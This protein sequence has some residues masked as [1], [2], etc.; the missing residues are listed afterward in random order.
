MSRKHPHTALPSRTAACSQ[1][2]FQ[3][4]VLKAG[5]ILS[6]AHVSASHSA[7]WRSRSSPSDDQTFFL[8]LQRGQTPGHV[9]DN[10]SVRQ[11]RSRLFFLFRA[12]ARDFR[13]A[14]PWHYDCVRD[15][16]ACLDIRFP[17]F[18]LRDP[19]T[20]VHQRLHGFIVGLGKRHAR[21]ALS[22]NF[23]PRYRVWKIILVIGIAEVFGVVCY[24]PVISQGKSNAAGTQN[25]SFLRMRGHCEKRKRA[26][27]QKKLP[28][29]QKI[30]T[31]MKRMKAL[32]HFCCRK[33]IRTSAH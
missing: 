4:P 9:L 1:A 23:F 25:V 12:R 17:V 6:T 13:R 29:H 20:R 30:L 28:D 21:I 10:H 26:K 2:A 7:I 18:D 31:I 32:L 3:Q 19:V 15:Y 27:A 22:L 16:V 24:R 33:S 8:R 5:S 14:E 11:F